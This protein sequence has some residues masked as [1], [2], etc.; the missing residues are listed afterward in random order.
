[1]QDM[2]PG[3]DVLA[4]ETLMKDIE[5]WITHLSVSA[6][7]RGTI[8]F[9]DLNVV[10][11]DFFADV[12]N[13]LYGW[14]LVN[15]NHQGLNAAAV[16]LGDPNQRVAVQVT[17]DRTK[18]KVQKTIDVFAANGLERDYD[19][20]YVLIIGARTGNYPG[21]TLPSG[22][23]F[24]GKQHVIDDERL[25]QKINSMSLT[26]LGRFKAYMD[27]AVRPYS[28]AVQVQLQTDLQVVEQLR[29]LLD[30]RALKDPWDAEGSLIAFKSALENILEFLNHGSIGGVPHSRA[31]HQLTDASLR[32]IADT[33][34]ERIRILLAMFTTEKRQGNLDIQNNTCNFFGTAKSR[35]FDNYRYTII[36]EFNQ[37][38][39]RHGVL[40]IL[41]FPPT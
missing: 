18:K 2:Q 21:L 7:L 34:Y 38:T 1:M 8:H 9:F 23:A 13:Q 14:H 11:E 40:P 20:L 22:V 6:R 17:S 15:L 41:V 12:L 32:T 30:R 37:A 16:D 26:D 19:H 35:S 25:L 28:P 29:A 27:E 39:Q 10:A 3:V 33:A 31:R 36:K 24:D 5:Y 4:K